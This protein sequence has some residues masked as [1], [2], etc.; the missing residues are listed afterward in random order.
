MPV[1]SA[2]PITNQQVVTVQV[3]PGIGLGQHFL[4][5]HN[6]QQLQVQAPPGAQPGQMVQVQ[7]PSGGPNY[8]LSH[9]Q[10]ETASIADRIY[11]TVRELG[12][13]SCWLDVYANDKTPTGMENG[14]K[15][16]DVFIA[17]LSPEYF[18]REF[19]LMELGWA[20]QYQKRVQPVILASK[21][22]TIGALRAAA[23]PEFKWLFQYNVNNV[24]T[25]DMDMLKRMLPLVLERAAQVAVAPGLEQ[26]M[27]VERLV[28]SVLPT[29]KAH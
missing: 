5:Q 3:P 29:R 26:G 7:V 21:K 25:S 23:P 17:I 2:A 18:S 22:S 11:S 6:G 27:S 12:L 14:V 4:I 10:D 24:D 20:Q 16:C 13:R 1:Q 19:C 15:N 9:V 28:E 8:F